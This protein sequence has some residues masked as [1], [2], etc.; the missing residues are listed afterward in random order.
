MKGRKRVLGTPGG[1][2]SSL[3]APP[4]GKWGEAGPE[5]DGPLRPRIPAAEKTLQ[6]ARLF[7]IRVVRLL[8]TH[9]AKPRDLKMTSQ[10]K[11]TLEP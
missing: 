7:A 11:P 3:G 5:V 10:R 4:C 1:H 2:G 8:V 9:K 6:Y